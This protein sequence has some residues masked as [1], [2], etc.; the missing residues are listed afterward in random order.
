MLVGEL[1]SEQLRG[2]EVFSF[3]YNNVWLKSDYAYQLDPDL[4]LFEGIQYLK[5]EKMLQK[6]LVQIFILSG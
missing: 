4:E 1:F 3:A 2:K 5:D 6:F